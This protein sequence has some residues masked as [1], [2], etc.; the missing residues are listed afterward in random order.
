MSNK[1]TFFGAGAFNAVLHVASGIVAWRISNLI[2]NSW[3]A[4][5]LF[6]D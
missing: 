2:S 3:D 5:V 4:L 6:T 1:S